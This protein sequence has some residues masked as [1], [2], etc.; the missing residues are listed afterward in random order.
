MPFPKAL[1]EDQSKLLGSL[2]DPVER[3][4]LEKGEEDFCI[5]CAYC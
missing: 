5:Q 3:Y 4:F 1:D 2:I